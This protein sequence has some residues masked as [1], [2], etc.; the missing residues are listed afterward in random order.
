M[1][2]ATVQYDHSSSANAPASSGIGG[3][4]LG[5]AAV[6][7]WNDVAAEGRDQF[8]EWHDKEHMPERLAIPGF[9]RGRRYI[10]QGHSPE[11]LT[12]YE[13][14]NLDV[15]TSAN[16]LARLNSPTSQTVATLRYFRNTSR[17]VCQLISSVG[18]S[19]G[20]HVLAMRLDVSEAQSQAMRTHLDSHVF[21]RAMALTGIVACHLYA[22]DPSAS[23]VHTAESRT[24]DFDVPSW[25]ILVEAT[26]FDAAGHAQSLVDSSA[27]SR[28]GVAVRND[29]AVYSLEISRLATVQ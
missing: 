1:N 25:V 12:L 11:W 23:F 16:Y 29:A 13:A 3:A 27:L 24:R 8:Y 15:V 7:V 21:P 20:G 10:N 28:L 18:S 2:E 19:S 17:A 6:V 26:R 14:G 22:A 9:R 5:R 4:L